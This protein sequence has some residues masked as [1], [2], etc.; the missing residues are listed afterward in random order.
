MKI[1]I[2]LSKSAQILNTSQTIQTRLG[3]IEFDN[4]HVYSF[5]RGL[6]GFESL[7][8]YIFAP[9]PN[10]ATDM[11]Y[12][13]LQSMEAPDLC[14]I[15][16]KID[17]TI[18]S[19]DFSRLKPFLEAVQLDVSDVL[20]GVIVTINPDKTNEE[21]VTYNQKAPLIFSQ[22]SHEGWQIILE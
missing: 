8:H 5:A 4:S 12:M 10:L 22:K 17:T 21:R 1:Q 7:R 2:E 13:V 3:V 14:F 11:N 15:V 20:V 6:Y 9:L 18:P 16:M 19:L